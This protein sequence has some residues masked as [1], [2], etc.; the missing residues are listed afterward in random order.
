MAK[1]IGIIEVGKLYRLLVG[2]NRLLP[3]DAVFLVLDC[4][5]LDHAV[6]IEILTDKGATATMNTSKELFDALATMWFEPLS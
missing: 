6:C 1:N 5:I 3:I 2:L 4:V